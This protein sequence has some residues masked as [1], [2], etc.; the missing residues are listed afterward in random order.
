M[1][2]SDFFLWFGIGGIVAV[3]V[4]RI[5]LVL[6]LRKNYPKIFAEIDNPSLIGRMHGFLFKLLDHEDFQAM[7]KS[8]KRIV[9]LFVVLFF[10]PFIFML[11][12]FATLTVSP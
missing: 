11:G 1:C 12:F 2:T 9:R 5:V 8:D 3:N 10:V 7:R 6:K 4:M